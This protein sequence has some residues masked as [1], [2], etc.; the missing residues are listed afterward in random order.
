MTFERTSQQAFFGASA[1]LFGASAALT[2]VW[3]A[4]MS[5]ISG[6]RMLGGSRMSVETGRRAALD[7][8]GS[9]RA[10][11]TPG[12]VHFFRNRED[13]SRHTHVPNCAWNARIGK[14]GWCRRRNKG[15][16]GKVEMLFPGEVFA[17]GK[18]A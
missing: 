7:G 16:R 9:S 1:L 4:S 15:E 12:T 2:T 13:S 5:D 10:R 6:M 8:E 14:L 18:A 17:E 3:C 11:I